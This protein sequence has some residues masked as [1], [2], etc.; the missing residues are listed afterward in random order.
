MRDSL[1]TQFVHYEIVFFCKYDLCYCVCK[2]DI[3]EALV[4]DV[5]S[6]RVVPEA[7]TM[8]ASGHTI[9]YDEWQSYKTNDCG[10]IFNQ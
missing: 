3:G 4:N 2:Q 1:W 6:V 9:A 10:L 7:R 5:M 8:S